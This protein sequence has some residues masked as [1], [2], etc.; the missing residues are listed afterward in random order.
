[1]SAAMRAAK[2]NEDIQRALKPFGQTGSVM[3][4]LRSDA[5]QQALATST[6][7]KE[8]R[9]TA[10]MLAAATGSSA[11]SEQMKSILTL[12]KGATL[13]GTTIGDI[14]AA[15]RFTSISAAGDL[16]IG[17]SIGSLIR[18]NHAVQT[19]TFATGGAVAE[20]LK[21]IKG[22][23]IGDSF[24]AGLLRDKS[25]NST[26]RQ[27][28]AAL[29]ATG[30]MLALSSASGAIGDDTF[31]RA[32]RWSVERSVVG[33]SIADM[34]RTTGIGERER[35][36]L[37]AGATLTASASWR[38][39]MDGA[40]GTS[41][42][43]LRP[44]VVSAY[45]GLHRAALPIVV[46]SSDFALPHANGA[47]AGHLA[48]HFARMQREVSGMMAPLRSA[49][50]ESRA[51]DATPPAS[52]PD[53]E[54][55]A[56]AAEFEQAMTEVAVTGTLD[57]L[58]RFLDHAFN[59]FA[60]NTE[61]E[62][63]GIGA[64]TLLPL[65]V[66][67]L[68]A[69]FWLQPAWTPAPEAAQPPGIERVQQEQHALSG[70]FDKLTELLAQQEADNLDGIPRVRVKRNAPVRIGPGKAY[71]KV[72]QLEAGEVVGTRDRENGWVLVFY[73]DP[74]SGALGSGWMYS[75]LL[76]SNGE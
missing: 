67:I 21:A 12:A 30:A 31:A 61:R 66:A 60:R 70:K 37:M 64:I 14:A 55:V 3:D 24:L 65:V 39:M 68:Q 69:L 71:P 59:V 54:L 76:E 27:I 36:A 50:A 23:A 73:R 42:A 58:L 40:I 10:A 38:T 34:M 72:W 52:I 33:T 53:R 16:G 43:G 8:H 51:F 45:A 32:A 18:A 56:V 49:L 2:Q 13:T 41:L 7:L 15:N 9:S 28:Q 35:K 5:V 1:M 44:S 57:A 48:D 4:M 17:G 62:L 74:L 46:R 22:M 6:A 25:Q 75:G 20:A 11:L 29:G 63:G 26:V 19:P 47:L